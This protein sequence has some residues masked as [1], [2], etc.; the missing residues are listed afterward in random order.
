MAKRYGVTAV[1]IVAKVP[2]AQGG[3]SYF[4]RNRILP[5]AVPAKEIRR[6]LGLGLIEEVQPLEEIAEQ[7]ELQRIEAEEQ[8]ATEF[9]ERVQAAAEKI[10]SEQVVP[11]FEKRVEARAEELLAARDDTSSTSTPPPTTPTTT[12]TPAATTPPAS[13]PSTAKTASK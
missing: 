13:K 7:L 5:E 8:L 3:E 12:T 6:L 4:R 11:E 1:M 10:V 2:G 9:D